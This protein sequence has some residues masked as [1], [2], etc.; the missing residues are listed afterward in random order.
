V[1]VWIELEGSFAKALARGAPPSWAVSRWAA[2][3][4][5]LWAAWLNPFFLF[6]EI[7]NS[8]P[9]LFL[10]QICIINI[11]SCRCPKIVKLILLGS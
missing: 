3:A 7:S 4:R 1:L 11:K 10:S 2:F 9:I 5:G 6:L 8:F